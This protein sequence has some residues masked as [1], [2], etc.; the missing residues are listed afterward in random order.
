MENYDPKGEKLAPL[1]ITV[2]P[3]RDTQAALAA[4]V[5]KFNPNILALTGTAEQVKAAEDAYKVFAA[6]MPPTGADYG[7]E[8]SGYVYL[9]SP[10]DKLLEVL[11][12][13]ETAESMIAKIKLHF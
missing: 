8:H 11:G 1:F 9:M 12:S 3:E 10:D 2:D 4:Y 7:V 13:D 5:G 6:K